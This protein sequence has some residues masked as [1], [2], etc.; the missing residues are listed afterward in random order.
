MMRVRALCHAA[1]DLAPVGGWIVV[2]ASLLARFGL[3][4]ITV[5]IL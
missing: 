1:F 3:G 2:I 4:C 5:I